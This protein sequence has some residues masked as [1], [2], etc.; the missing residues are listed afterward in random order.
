M[1]TD[2]VKI[3]DVIVWMVE[4]VVQMAQQGESVPNDSLDL[5][6]KLVGLNPDGLP[7]LKKSK[8][9][10]ALVG[11]FYE[12]CEEFEKNIRIHRSLRGL[13]F[14]NDFW[15]SKESFRQFVELIGVLRD[16]FH[17]KNGTQVM[18]DETRASW[19]WVLQENKL[20]QGFISKET[21]GE[22][23]TR[24][25][26]LRLERIQAYLQEANSPVKV[27]V[28]ELEK[29]ERQWGTLEPIYT[30]MARFSGNH[31][32]H[33]EMPVL[34]E[35]FGA[36]LKGRF[37]QYKFS[38]KEQLAP[39]RSPEI[40]KWQAIRNRLSIFKPD[41]SAVSAEVAQANN[42][43]NARNI[44]HTN[45][46]L[47]MDANALKP[48]LILTGGIRETLLSQVLDAQ[49]PP[50]F[51]MVIGHLKAAAVAR[52]KESLLATLV[53]ELT[54]QADSK[55]IQK[56]TRFLKDGRDQMKLSAQTVADLDS[57]L[58]AFRVQASVSEKPA[59]VFTTTFWHP[60][61]LLTVGDL[62]CTGSCQ[63]YKTGGHIETLPGYVIDSNVQGVASFI[64]NP[65]SFENV[66]DYR[67]IYAALE[68]GAVVSRH[69]DPA[70]RVL[71]MVV[72][73]R[74]I[75]T[76]PFDYAQM[77]QMLKLGETEDGKPALHLERPYE[78]PHPAHG[79]M[80]GQAE[81][82]VAEIGQ[83]I[84]AIPGAAMKVAKSRNGGGVYSDWA[85]RPGVQT[86]DY[87]FSHK[88]M[89]LIPLKAR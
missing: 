88:P 80:L 20:T 51:K 65:G 1:L 37:E 28:H 13:S 83:A 25:K 9:S 35:I 41:D 54:V 38:D 56:I 66:A 60:K 75:Q 47:N 34:G 82:I 86:D 43:K 10:S 57:V 45:L 44:I 8:P 73:G 72:N 23:L 15:A 40:K 22:I 21:I 50:T 63:N 61:A 59:I 7:D 2:R 68:A 81:D 58:K 32:W 70:H 67:A 24:A 42:L 71:R 29:L 11:Q 14:S 49:N 53:N 19:E 16:L 55:N 62:V 3:R 5:V 31:S 52:P 84:G 48:E 79:F 69:F 76:L 89:R 30:L 46:A 77:R 36:V 64:V 17:L 33:E 85:I 39:L 87:Y 18:V 26:T 6:F 4:E 27:S 78:Q 12:L 74:K